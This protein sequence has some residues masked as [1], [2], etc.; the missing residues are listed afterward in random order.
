M[1]STTMEKAINDQINAEIYSAYLYLAMSAYFESTNLPGFA[2]W[3]R[4]QVQE[5]L[6]HADKFYN[7]V[8]DCRGRVT[9]KKID[10]PETEWDSPMAVFEATLEH[11]QKV[12]SL[13]NKLVDSALKEHDHASNIFLQWFV[14]E[15]VEEE[16]NADDIIQKIKRMAD[17]PGGLMMLD[18]ELAQR[19]FTPPAATTEGT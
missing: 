6:T 2:N 17:M 9:L 14:T 4:V 3:M 15:Q 1:L 5:E 10:G 7:F 18:N 13:I 12:T 19:V 16:K 11:E 8:H